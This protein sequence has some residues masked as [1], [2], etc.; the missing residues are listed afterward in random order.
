MPTPI[1]KVTNITRSNFVSVSPEQIAKI[2]LALYDSFKIELTGFVP[3]GVAIFQNLIGGTW[4][5]VQILPLDSTG[6]L[7][8]PPTP[9]TTDVGASKPYRVLTSRETSGEIDFTDIPSG[10]N[11]PVETYRGIGIYLNQDGTYSILVNG[12]FMGSYASITEA[13]VEIDYLLAP[14]YTLTISAGLGGTTTPPAGVYSYKANTSLSIKANP[15]T[16]YEL[17]YWVVNGA[18]PTQTVNPVPI[19]VSKDGFTVQAVFAKATTHW[20]YEYKLV[21]QWEEAPG[22]PVTLQASQDETG[23][24]MSSSPFNLGD[25]KYFMGAKITY[26]I[27]YIDGTVGPTV[28]IDC[29]GTNVVSGVIDKTPG[30]ENNPAFLTGEVNITMLLTAV[31][32][33]IR[34]GQNNIIVVGWN[35]IQY[36]CTVVLGYSQKPDTPPGTNPDPFAFLK[37]LQWYQWLAIGAFGLGALYVLAGKRDGGGQG[38]SIHLGEYARRGYSAVKSRARK[39]ISRAREA[40]SSHR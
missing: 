38:V 14:N 37:N 31:N 19:I 24:A 39:K 29:N 18:I 4:T 23:K 33:T 8:I 34:V 22:S 3:S 12:Q 40:S 15:S 2:Y 20:P 21:N 27:R 11:L 32:N 28:G 1:F 5:T 16:G 36:D 35:K 13:R 9:I 26:T 7:T 17:D 6:A 30:V 25:T 10:P